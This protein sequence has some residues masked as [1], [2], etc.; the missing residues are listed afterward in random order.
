[1][2][3]HQEAAAEYPLNKLVNRFRKS[4]SRG[5]MY[6][7]LVL[8]CAFYKRLLNCEGVD[9][10]YL[11]D[12]VEAMHRQMGSDIACNYGFD[13]TKHIPLPMQPSQIRLRD[14]A[15]SSEKNGYRPARSSGL[16]HQ[17]V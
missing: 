5:K 3:N 8:Q 9:G 7:Y 15:G 12:L 2:C 11:Q 17:I 13:H 10:Q 14:G 6:V 16:R 4:T 1:M